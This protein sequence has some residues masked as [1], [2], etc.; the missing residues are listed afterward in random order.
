LLCT[1]RAVSKNGKE[2][3][4]EIAKSAKRKAKKLKKAD[5]NARGE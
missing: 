2:R 5:I 1:S 4:E 3:G